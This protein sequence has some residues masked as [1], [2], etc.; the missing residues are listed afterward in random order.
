MK[1]EI[2]EK[3]LWL[4]KNDIVFTPD[5]IAEKLVKMFKPTGKILEPCKGEGAFMKFLPKN[6]DWCEIADGRDF[7]DYTKKV[8]WIITNPPYSNF[9]DFLKHSMEV[10]NNIVFLVPIAKMLKSWGTIKK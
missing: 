5:E 10:A 7:F 9:D 2:P 4:N 6:T 3:Y 8:D 1:K